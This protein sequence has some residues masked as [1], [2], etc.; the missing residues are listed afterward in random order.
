[1]PKNYTNRK[2]SA[3]YPTDLTAWQA[4]KSHNGEMRKRAITDL[5]AKDAKRVEKF[6]LT[7]GNLTL[8][9]SKNLISAATTKL[10]VRLAKEASVPAA[11]DAMFSGEAINKTEGRAAL[12]VALRSKIS[13]QVALETPGVKEVWQV[14]TNK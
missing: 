10:F 3:R 1:M 6:T 4:L 7:A 9:Y 8:D 2:L 12:H 5:F 13:D 14:L 11:I